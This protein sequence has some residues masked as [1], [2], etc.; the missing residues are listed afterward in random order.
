MDEHC[1]RVLEL[2]I[3]KTMKNLEKNNMKP[4]YAPTKEEA[5]KLVES[6]MKEGET[7]SCGGTMT[8]RDCG[9]RDLMLSGK[10]EF[11]DRDRPGITPEEIQEIYRKAFW[12]DT[13]LTSANAVTENG[14]LFNVDGNSNRVAAIVFG[15]KSVI[16]VAGYNKIVADLDEAV[17]RVKKIAA[18]ANG[19]RLHT[20][21]PC[22]KTGECIS[23]AQGKSAGMTDGCHSAGRMCCSY[24]VSA[25]QRHKD[26]IKVILVGEP[27]GY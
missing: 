8:L 4:Y 24:V 7:I 2:R 17:L 6:L 26:R 12:A 10:Y 13:Y 22:E 1:K 3:Q 16:V 5:V 25:A 23:C 21:T 27:L 11:L 18:P 15:P 14:E 20:G 9:I 19:C